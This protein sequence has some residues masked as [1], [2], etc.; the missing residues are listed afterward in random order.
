MLMSVTCIFD[1]QFERAWQEHMAEQTL[2]DMLRDSGV[3]D[4]M[5]DVSLRLDTILQRWRR[6]ITKRELGRQA[7]SA[8][9][10]SIDMAQL[11]VLFAIQGPM[12]DTCAKADEEV[13]IGTI[14]ER[15]SIDPSRASRLVSDVVS[16][17]YAM[18]MASQ[19][20]SRRTVIV[21][22]EQ[23]AAV[24]RAVRT[25]KFL[26][27]GTYLRDWEPAEAEALVKLLQRFGEWSDRA[28]IDR[29][30]E[31]DRQV[32]ILAEQ[33]AQVGRQKVRA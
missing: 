23:G 6:R 32:E 7:I 27:M 14:G 26:L 8:L 12:V 15:L 17:G 21:L 1:E 20:D 29:G 25:Y 11:D 24:T 16:G 4:A 2:M 31:F 19:K 3:D 5:I 13:T 33:V 28:S 22:T 18:R 10:L 30:S 9:G